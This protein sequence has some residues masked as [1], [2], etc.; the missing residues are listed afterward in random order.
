M[1]KERARE[2]LKSMGFSEWEIN[3]YIILVKYGPQ[4]ALELAR[5]SK[6]ARSKT[7][8]VATRLRKKG[9]VMKVPPMPT[10]GVTQKFVA[11]S[12]EKVFP[13]KISE[14]QKLLEYL[15]S[16]YNNPVKARFP[17]INFYTS[18]EA[19]KELFSDVIK[20]SKFFYFYLVNLDLK[21]I[22]GYAFEH[23]LADISKKKHHFLLAE[24]IELKQLSKNLKNVSFIHEKEGV[25][26]IITSESVI[27][28]L[29]QSQHIII[30]INSEDAVK[31]FLFM[32]SHLYKTYK[33]QLS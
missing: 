4:T 11:I 16:L 30:E 23:N 13:S 8:E 25:N 18:K 12:P 6:V 20:K 32:Y 15:T 27:M 22:L 2:L 7:Y 5:L 14:M 29:W 21:S 3:T 9:L 26:Y 1:D 33:T 17:N 19:V 31:T 24:T 10:K 28:D